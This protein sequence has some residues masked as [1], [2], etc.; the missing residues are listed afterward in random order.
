M[1]PA[2]PHGLPLA[3]HMGGRAERRLAALVYTSAGCL[4]VRC[5]RNHSLAAPAERSKS[6][7]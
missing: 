3:R 4:A 6:F 2:G 7:V 5:W 1:G